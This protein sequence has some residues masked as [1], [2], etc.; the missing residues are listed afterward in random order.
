MV[1]G[2]IRGAK[3]VLPPAPYLVPSRAN[4]S[5][6][7]AG[8]SIPGRIIWRV[9]YETSGKKK[10]R[11]ASLETKRVLSGDGGGAEEAVR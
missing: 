2:S 8:K 11:G 6:V 5:P 9:E 10:D 7:E 3:E 1:R 4:R